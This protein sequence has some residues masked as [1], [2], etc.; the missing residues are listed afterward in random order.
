MENIIVTVRLKPNAKQNLQ[1]CWKVL[2]E[3]HH[4]VIVNMRNKQNYVFDYVFNEE[5]GNDMIFNILA[6]PLVQSSIE[7]INSTIFAYG[8]TSSGKTHTIR[9]T[10]TSPGLIMQ[11]LS[12]LFDF[13]QS[14]QEKFQ[15]KIS[16]L[17]I[18]NE[19]IND[20]LDPS[21]T[22]LEIREH[23]EKG[24]YIDKLSEFVV[25]CKSKAVELLNLG[26][27]LRK[28]AETQMNAQS[29]RSHSVFK[30]L[31]DNSND[32]TSK[33]SQF[34]L[35]DLAGSEGMTKSK[36]ED[37]RSRE[38][39][40]INK[41]LL[42][43]SSVIQKLSDG[44]G[45]RGFINFRDSKITRLLQPSLTGNSRTAIIC[46]INTDSTFYQESNNTLLFGIRAKHIK[47]DV[48]V[49]LNL[50]AEQQMKDLLAENKKLAERV[51]ELDRVVQDL[52]LEKNGFES[53]LKDLAR[54]ERLEGDLKGKVDE[55][56][57]L[58]RGKDRVEEE[59]RRRFEEALVV[60]QEY[61]GKIGH[62]WDRIALL[63][64]R[65]DQSLLE[66]E[67]IENQCEGLEE[68]VRRRD[69]R[70]EIAEREVELGQV[71]NRKL[72]GEV[73][74]LQE[75]LG[76]CKE[77]CKVLSIKNL[78]LNEERI[79]KDN[80]IEELKGNL[81]SIG[82]AYAGLLETSQ[83]LKLKLL[84]KDEK[85]IKVCQENSILSN[86]L[87]SLA[88]DSTI[89]QSKVAELQSSCFKYE[90]ALDALAKTSEAQT[91]AI[92]SKKAKLKALKS[93][94]S[95]EL[96][97]KE[98]SINE[99]NSKNLSLNAELE[100]LQK[101]LDFQIN[102]KLL[103]EQE[104][105]QLEY[106]YNAKDNSISVQFNEKEDFSKLLNEKLEVL[107]DYERI[108]A[109]CG[110]LERKVES[111][112][113]LFKEEQGRSKALQEEKD[114]INEKY[115]ESQGK[116]LELVKQMSSKRASI[117]LVEKNSFEP[118]EES[119]RF[120]LKLQIA[121][122]QNEVKILNEEKIISQQ[123]ITKLRESKQKSQ[124]PSAELILKLSELESKISA[125]HNENG[126]LKSQI[127]MQSIQNPTQTRLNLKTSNR[128]FRKLDLSN[129]PKCKAM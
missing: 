89:L 114:F 20:L 118:V 84:E 119:E 24:I 61:E 102:E 71:E 35:V 73:K 63:G 48:N 103:I 96:T 97:S 47:N 108:K 23:P 9:G 29:S 50:V 56:E 125:L 31:I 8:Q 38:G 80:W 64:Q 107:E 6:L 76:R 104:N 106:L 44:K 43:L 37:L 122:L 88:S 58:V 105:F 13:I 112:E 51:A 126:Y 34:N 18:Y 99:L 11:S 93:Q 79:E 91:K 12:Y 25:T 59:L 1:E 68:E 111:L 115:L 39:S 26:E 2:K 66:R 101:E 128:Q 127:E 69:E 17:E 14:S 90:S 15:I 75:G 109:S 62:A 120:Q 40:N 32:F 67:R 60:N 123:E 55:L 70:W 72:M 92:K 113:R 86:N 121:E 98:T 85:C 28:V 94:H 117:G 82:T 78:E 46:N 53:K 3:P 10:A 45:Q 7:G 77:D 83:E 100:E 124:T 95:Q 116:V 129:S 30:V 4:N 27:S 57:A 16:F 74:A 87:E 54:L 52:D 110:D 49:N 65:I 5:S 22:N 19:Q 33:S 41:S 81:D 36:N 42:S 21:K